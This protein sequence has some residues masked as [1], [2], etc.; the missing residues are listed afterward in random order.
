MQKTASMFELCTAASAMLSPVDDLVIEQMHRFG[1]NLGMAFQIVDDVLDYTG[2]SSQ[3]G[4]PV[5]SDLRQGIIT[6]PAIFFLLDNPADPA[7]SVVMNGNDLHDSQF[8]ELIGKIKESGA[9]EKSLE[10]A[11]D[12]LETS[13]QLLLDFPE[14][15][16]KS[17]LLEILIYIV[18]RRV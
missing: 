5:G 18:R 14:S 7:M 8:D 16:Y 11:N 2:E 4:K 6:L 1:R 15:I 9:I 17:S 10:M 3:V 13:R 12:Y